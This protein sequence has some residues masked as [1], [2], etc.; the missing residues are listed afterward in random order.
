MRPDS[1]RGPQNQ[2]HRRTAALE[3]GRQL[4]RAIHFAVSDNL[5]A[6]TSSESIRE[7]SITRDD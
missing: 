5:I 4:A 3:R 2:S 1:H 6:A 7:P